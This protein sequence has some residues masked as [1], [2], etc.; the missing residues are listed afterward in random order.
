M[1]D[2]KRENVFKNKSG[3]DYCFIRIFWYIVFFILAVTIGWG[4]TKEQRKKAMIQFPEKKVEA[5]LE[6]CFEQDIV[7]SFLTS[8]GSYITYNADTALTD[9]SKIQ[10]CV[11]WDKDARTIDNGLYTNYA[12]K[13]V[14][15]YTDKYG[16]SCRGEQSS[17]RMMLTKK[18][19]SGEHSC[20]ERCLKE[21]W[22][23]KYIQSGQEIKLELF[24][25]EYHFYYLT[26][27]REEEIS[28]NDI[29][30]SLS[31]NH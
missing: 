3:I 5:Y 23:S 28:Y 18:D 30:N 12:E 7:V 24:S 19:L 2:K 21:L 4:I 10:F 29:L 31:T 11:W 8:R 1:W 9:G 6:T 25:E 16:L 26:I 15:Y 22:N 20:L 13:L 17:F 27:C 14:N